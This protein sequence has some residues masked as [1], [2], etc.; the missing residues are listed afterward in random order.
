VAGLLVN[1]NPLALGTDVQTAAPLKGWQGV[2][3]MFAPRFG[4]VVTIPAHMFAVDMHLFGN[5]KIKNL[6]TENV[7]GPI[8]SN[9]PLWEQFV[10]NSIMRS[11]FQE[12]AFLTN[13]RNWGVDTQLIQAQNEAIRGTLERRFQELYAAA[14]KKNGITKQLASYEASIA[15]SR[16]FQVNSSNYKKLLNDSKKAALAI[17]GEKIFLGLVSPVTTQ[18][19]E[20]DPTLRSEVAKYSLPKNQ[21]G[22]GIPFPQSIDQMFKDH[23]DWTPEGLFKSKSTYGTVLPETLGVMNA[24]D[25]SGEMLKRNP[26]VGWAFV[27]NDLSAMPKNSQSDVYQPAVTALLEDGFRQRLMPEDFIKSFNTTIGNNLYYNF[28][29]QIYTDWHDNKPSQTALNIGLPAILNKSKAYQWEQDWIESYGVNVNPD[30][31]Q[32][33]KAGGSTIA[34]Q[35]AIADIKNIYN[36]Q[37]RDYQPKLANSNQGK[38]IK[39]VFIDYLLPELEQAKAMAKTGKNGLSFLVVKNWWNATMDQI[40]KNKN[41][42]DLTNAVN[43]VFRNAA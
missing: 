1:P 27:S 12:S 36:P 37:S 19:G 8:G 23:P 34:H 35:Q 24:L 15:V 40:L 33:Y 21:G 11:M 29:K 2:R 14:L 38:A 17:F 20:Y 25:Q 28:V 26:R 5:G 42:A 41:L 30:W 13:W 22:K 32:S 4:P 7:L 3:E 6:V 43:T 9:M 31:Y 16:E 10:P 39:A 18:V